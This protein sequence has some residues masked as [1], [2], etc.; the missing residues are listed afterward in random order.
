[1]DDHS[2]RT[3]LLKLHAQDPLPA[4]QFTTSQR[5]AL[6]RLARQNGAVRCQRQGRGDRYQIRR[7]QAVPASLRGPIAA[8]RNDY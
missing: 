3:A 7:L 6:D 2:L 1:M 8:D 4:S 5:Q